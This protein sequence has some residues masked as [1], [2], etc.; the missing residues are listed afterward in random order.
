MLVSVLKTIECVFYLGLTSTHKFR[1]FCP[2]LPKLPK[3]RDI[4]CFFYQ[5]S[6]LMKVFSLFFIGTLSGFLTSPLHMTRWRTTLQSAT[7]QLNDYHTHL[8]RK[9]IISPALLICQ[10]WRL[11]P[12]RHHLLLSILPPWQVHPKFIKANRSSETCQ[13]KC[14]FKNGFTQSTSNFQSLHTPEVRR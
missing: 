2:P 7:M 5:F 1:S 12:A 4:Y 14:L 6:V 11:T 3:I 9:H 10:Y 8:P 13:L